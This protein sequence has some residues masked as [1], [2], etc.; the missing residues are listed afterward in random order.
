ML[1]ALHFGWVSTSGVTMKNP[2]RK[3]QPWTVP[4]RSLEVVISLQPQPGRTSAAGWGEPAPS[5]TGRATRRQLGL[6]PSLPT[7]EEPCRDQLW[8]H[9]PAHCR[10]QVCFYAVLRPHSSQEILDAAGL[11]QAPTTQPRKYLKTPLNSKAGPAQFV[12]I[13]SL[14]TSSFLRRSA[15]IRRTDGL[16]EQ[17]VFFFSY[18]HL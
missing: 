10:L 15:V 3:E 12:F 17:K 11:G 7:L 6:P 14:I 9:F 18:P 1:A 8:F 16:R 4:R 13:S 2:G 5:S